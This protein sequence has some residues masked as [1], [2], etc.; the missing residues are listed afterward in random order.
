MLKDGIGL[1]V[2]SSR[3][4]FDTAFINQDI[5]DSAVVGEERSMIR[6]CRISIFISKEYVR[7]QR[8]LRP[9]LGA[10]IADSRYTSARYLWTKLMA[11]EPSPTADATRFMAP[12]RTSP[13]AKTPGQLVSSR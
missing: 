5:P 3:D 13:A 6:T 10:K 12:D 11:I 8:G 2:E 9:L 4:G 1:S 7:G